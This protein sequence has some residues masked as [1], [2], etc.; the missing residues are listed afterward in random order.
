M[1][2]KKR[3]MRIFWALFTISE[4]QLESIFPKVFSMAVDFFSDVN[5]FL[6]KANNVESFTNQKA[7]IITRALQGSTQ[8]I[9]KIQDHKMYFI[10][11]Y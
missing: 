5:D 8:L 10:F 11:F 1:F 3:E 7:Y 4:C 9:K 6:N 2:F